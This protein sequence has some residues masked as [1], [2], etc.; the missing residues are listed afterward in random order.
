MPPS[1][2]TAVAIREMATRVFF[3]LYQCDNL[4]HKTA[5]KALDKFGVTSQQWAVLGALSR[6]HVDDGLT[7]GEL[8]QFL[9][10][11]RQNLAGVLTRLERRDLIEKTTDGIDARARRVRTTKEG[12]KLW[13]DMQP[14]VHAYY[15]NMLHGFSFEDHVGML[16]YLQRLLRRMERQI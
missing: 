7:V 4:M 3:R 8:A 11:S 1:E 16:H 9:K 5:T 6:P 12:K 10:V 13:R 2:N 15:E 14:S